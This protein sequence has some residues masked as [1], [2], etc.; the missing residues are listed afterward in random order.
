MLAR[1][2]LPRLVVST[3]QMITYPHQHSVFFQWLPP[4][5]MAVTDKYIHIASGT[6]TRDSIQHPK[7]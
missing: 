3:T 1:P 4:E 5:E 7:P 2:T 6:H